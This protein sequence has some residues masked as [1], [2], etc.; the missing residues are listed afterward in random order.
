MG[1]S[2]EDKFPGSKREE[3]SRLRKKIFLKRVELIKLRLTPAGKISLTP[4]QQKFYDKMEKLVENNETILKGYK[5]QKDYLIKET[6]KDLSFLKLDLGRQICAIK[7]HKERVLSI[8]YNSRRGART[9]V[10]CKRC[11]AMYERSLT[12]E[13]KDDFYK[14]MTTPFNI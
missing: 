4:K 5:S 10:R 1:K 14:I 12:T 6:Q 9:Y 7:G 3:T 11:G 2:I 8:A 13:E